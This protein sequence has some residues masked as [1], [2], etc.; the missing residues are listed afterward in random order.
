MRK[1][2]FTLIELLVVIAIIAILAAILFPV[3]AQAREKARSISCLSNCRQIGVALMMYAQD[4]DEYSPTADHDSEDAANLY[5]WYGPL[6]PYIKNDG[7]FRCPSVGSTLPTLFAEPLNASLWSTVRTD[8][9]I[10][11][12]FA[13]SIAYAAISAPAEQIVVSERRADFAAFDY[14]P[15]IEEHDTEDEEHDPDHVVWER[16]QIDGSGFAVDSV[17]PDPRNLGRHQL[18]SNYVFGDG[19]AKFHRFT[20]TLQPGPFGIGMHNRDNLPPLEWHHDH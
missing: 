11:G 9:L 16:G 13:H 8:Y 3:F 1:R 17:T 15:W 19:H 7:V 20:Q 5:P 4:Y 2:A 10:N 18:G 6:Q 14:H 12:F